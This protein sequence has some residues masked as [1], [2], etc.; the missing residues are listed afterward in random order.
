MKQES[1][2]LVGYSDS[3]W[4]GSLDDSKSTTRFCFS[5]NSAVFSQNSKKQSIVAQ[6]TA[7]AEYIATT[8][9]VNQLKWLRKILNDLGFKQDKSTMIFVD[10]LSAIAIAKNLIHHGRTKHIKVKYHALGE[11]VIAVQRF[12]QLIY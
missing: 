5:F 2:D 11:A 10:N 7:K 8:A 4:A 6:C 3:D 9:A 1:G 12:R